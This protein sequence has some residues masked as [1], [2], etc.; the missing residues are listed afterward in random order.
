MVAET[1][2]SFIAGSKADRCDECALEKDMVAAV[3]FLSHGVRCE[4]V[5]DLGQCAQTTMESM[6]A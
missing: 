6:R 5:V 2:V 3:L 4:R 1:G